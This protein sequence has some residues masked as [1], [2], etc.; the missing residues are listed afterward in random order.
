MKKLTL[1]LI[2]GLLCL[3]PNVFGQA[4]SLDRPPDTVS[5]KAIGVRNLTDQE[6]DTWRAGLALPFM[7]FRDGTMPSR[8]VRATGDIWVL[9]DTANMRNLYLG[10]G[11]DATLI[12]RKHFRLG[13][14]V[15]WSA[16]FSNLEHIKRG[17]WGVGV[18][19]NWRF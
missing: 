10:A 4:I 2:V 17:S 3:V 18:S 7:N 5:I 12:E 16:D 19:A 15:G 13:G 14:T 1:T 6:S 8:P 11:L 9:T